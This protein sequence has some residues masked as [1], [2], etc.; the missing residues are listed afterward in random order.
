MSKSACSHASPL[1]EARA[2]RYFAFQDKQSGIMQI[3][4]YW[5]EQSYFNTGQNLELEHAKISYIAYT[6]K[7][8]DIPAIEEKLL[9]FALPFVNNWQPIKQWSQ[10]ALLVSQNGNT[11]LA[12]TAF[13]LAAVVSYGFMKERERKKSNLRVYNRLASEEERL[14]LQA[15]HRARKDR[16]TASTIAAHY[17]K[18]SGKP[19]ELEAVVEKLEEIQAAGLVTTDIDVTEDEPR[20]VWKSQIALR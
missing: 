2:A 9:Q 14:I 3:V 13:V 16:P 12:V 17:Q 10:F 4:L 15:V 11:L 5:Y 7:Q 20:L 1:K 6:D 19:I 18:L 8:G